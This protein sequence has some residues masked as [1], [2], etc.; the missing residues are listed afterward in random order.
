MFL[1]GRKVSLARILNHLVVRHDRWIGQAEEGVCTRPDCLRVHRFAS[2][3][4]Q[5]KVDSGASCE[6]KRRADSERKM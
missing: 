5:L 6:G 2:C 1:T 3:L 4:L